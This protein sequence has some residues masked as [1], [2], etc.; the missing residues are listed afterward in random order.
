[1]STETEELLRRARTEV[2]VGEPPVAETIA[3]GRRGARQ[4][5]WRAG[6]AVVA[7]LGVV[8]AVTWLVRGGSGASDVDTLDVVREVNPLGTAWASEG[9]LHL[10]DSTVEVGGTS[11]DDEVAGIVD[12][13]KG[14]VYA[15]SGRTHGGDVFLVT[16][17]GQRTRIG[18]HVHAGQLASDAAT[19]LVAWVEAPEAVGGEPPEIVAFDTEAGREVGRERLANTGERVDWLDEGPAPISVHGRTV[20]FEGW[21]ADYEW[22]IGERPLLRHDGEGRVLDQAEHTRVMTASDGLL[23]YC[24]SDCS[25]DPSVVFATWAEFSPSAASLVTLDDSRAQVLTGDRPPV[26]LRVDTTDPASDWQV[27]YVSE[28]QILVLTLSPADN[29]NQDG[30]RSPWQPP[31][32]I[33]GCSPR[34]GACDRLVD[35]L[36]DVLLAQ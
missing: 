20:W 10:A 25:P 34:T 28:S 21:D 23:S 13:P 6:G 22:Q 26:T 30:I 35:D 1:M 5:R 29:A 11:P 19:G 8:V 18:S 32:V 24:L 12:V 2:G 4:S 17:S 14:A 3:R 9:R 31:F 16:E 7:T 33:W 15:T 27:R 36:P